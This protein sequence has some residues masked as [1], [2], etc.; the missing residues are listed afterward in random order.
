MSP[1]YH[2]GFV[3]ADIEAAARELTEALGVAWGEIRDRRLGEWDYRIVFSV[4]GPP[5][6][7]LLEGPPGSPWDA[8]AGSR[9]D[10]LGYWAADLDADQQALAE[11]GAPLDFDGTALGRP[12]TYHRLDAV[13]VRAELVDGAAQPA[14]LEEWAP[15]L[16]PMPVLRVA[17]D[18]PP[19]GTSPAGVAACRATLVD[20]LAAV[21]HGRATD[22][23]DLFTPDAAFA[24]R[25]EQLHGHDAILAFLRDREAETERHTAHVVTNDVVRSATADEVVLTAMLLLHERDAGGGY[26]IRRVLDTTQT[27]RRDPDRWR[28][29]ERSTRPVHG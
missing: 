17:D 10:H 23:L 15:H 5:F 27:F 14:W 3:V 9:L 11:R 2:L 18:R 22:A 25:G 12:F 4:D 16:A 24:A 19:A 26:A 1:Y 28:I 6:L 8:S 13:G 21:D 7:E 29:R 20:F